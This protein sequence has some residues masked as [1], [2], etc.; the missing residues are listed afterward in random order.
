VLGAG[1]ARDRLSYDTLRTLAVLEALVDDVLGWTRY[2][3][4]GRLDVE[5]EPA[6]EVVDAAGLGRDLRSRTA[7]NP[8]LRGTKRR[9]AAEQRVLVARGAADGRTVLIVPEVKDKQATGL[10]LLHVTLRDDL[11]VGTLRSVLEGYRERY[12]AL[13]DAVLETE[14]A[15]RDDVLTTVD[16]TELMTDPINDLA[17]CWRAQRS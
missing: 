7:T 11:A 15:F 6:I 14:P 13:R 4:D 10:T 5:Q 8:V 2:G 9:V 16:I 3:I 1:A 17:R 12:T